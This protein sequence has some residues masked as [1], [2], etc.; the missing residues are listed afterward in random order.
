[1]ENIALDGDSDADGDDNGD[2]NGD[3]TVAQPGPYWIGPLP[4]AR[5]ADD[6]FNIGEPERIRRRIDADQQRNLQRKEDVAEIAKD[7]LGFLMEKIQ[8]KIQA[9]K[10][11]E[12]A[13]E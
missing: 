13:S 7:T 2:D 3:A 1:M 12:E 6:V 5:K 4:K 10:G 9:K 11:M 8:A